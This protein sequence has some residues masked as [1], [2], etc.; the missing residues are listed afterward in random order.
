MFLLTFLRGLRAAP[1]FAFGA[2]AMISPEFL[3]TSLVPNGY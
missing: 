2:A 1:A 3:W